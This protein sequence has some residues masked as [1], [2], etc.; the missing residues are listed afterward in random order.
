MARVLPQG[1]EH[2]S[3]SPCLKGTDQVLPLP[4]SLKVPSH[5]HSQTL[6][7]QGT[8]SYGRP[9]ASDPDWG[10]G[11]GAGGGPRHLPRSTGAGPEGPGTE[12]RPSPTRSSPALRDPTSARKGPPPFGA[13]C[14]LPLSV[15][16]LKPS[17]QQPPPAHPTYRKVAP[18]LWRGVIAS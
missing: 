3:G 11:G 7:P 5:S 2:P 4:Q 18:E 6:S 14:S 13:L 17:S 9:A 1:T 12:L 10:D 15:P 8:P 16:V